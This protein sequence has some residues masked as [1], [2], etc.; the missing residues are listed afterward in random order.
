MQI[1]RSD[2]PGAL[3]VGLFWSILG[4]LLCWGAIAIVVWVA[5]LG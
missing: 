4:S 5:G 2:P 1:E 3:F